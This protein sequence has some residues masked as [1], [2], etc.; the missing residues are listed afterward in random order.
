[1]VGGRKREDTTWAEA[2]V[3][4][5]HFSIHLWALNPET[6]GR[7]SVGLGIALCGACVGMSF[8]TV[9]RARG[10]YFPGCV[11]GLCSLHFSLPTSDYVGDCT[12]PRSGSWVWPVGPA[13]SAAPRKS[14]E[15]RDCSHVF[16][17]ASDMGSWGKSVR[18]QWEPLG[19]G[20]CTWLGD[21]KP[22][23]MLFTTPTSLAGE[24]SLKTEE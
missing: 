9:P 17:S 22:C 12:H 5:T 3:M 20:S 6:L 10:T 16:N 14:L 18:P 15:Q 23:K 19:T 1:M 8:L 13:G 21:A 4:A 24:T 7:P 2:K 11:L